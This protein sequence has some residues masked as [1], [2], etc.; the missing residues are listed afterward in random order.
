MKIKNNDVFHAPHLARAFIAALG[1]KAERD[2]E[3]TEP[4]ARALL[5]DAVQA[6]ASDLHLDPQAGAINVRFR[7]D[8]AVHEVASLPPE[9]GLRLL[10]YFKVNANLDPAPSLLPEDSHFEF[11]LDGKALD[12]RLACAPCLFGDKLALRLLRRS[13]VKHRLPDLG[14]RNEDHARIEA[15]LGDISGMFLVAGPVGSGKTTTLY[16]LLAELHLTE[17]HIVTIEDPVEYQLEHLNQMEVNV[18]RGLTFERGLR[19]ILRVDPDYILLGE[20]RDKESALTAME[21]AT[22][23]RVVFSTMHSRNAAGAVTALRSLGV[24]DYEIAASLAFVVGQ[25]LVRK[26]CTHCRRLDPPSTAERKWLESLGEKVP[27]KAWHPAGCEHCGQT[28][29]YDRTGVF[30]VL[31]VEERVY[32]SILAGEDEHTLRDHLRAD[33]FRT[34]LRDG[35]DKAAEGITDLSELTRIGVQS[36][37]DRAPRIHDKATTKK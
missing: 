29:Y 26:L 35:L 25:R 24:P 37:L 20:I 9:R 1:E 6:R 30:E 34:L 31:P 19:S 14:L 3:I 18:K 32:D 28:G 23:G 22:T 21:A 15:W 2:E 13:S 12:I 11:E 7:I 10:R 36:Y 16:A 4:W 33:G 17:R 5:T 8:G 27:D